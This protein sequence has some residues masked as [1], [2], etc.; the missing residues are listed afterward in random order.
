MKNKLTRKLMLS[1]FTLLFAVISLGASTY[2]WFTMS[3]SAK[4][5]AFN[6]NVK[7]GQGIEIA[8]TSTKD[9]GEA[10]WYV[11]EVPAGVIQDVA[12]ADDFEFDAVTINNQ[13]YNEVTFKD[14]NNAAKTGGYIS[15]FVHV[16]AAQKGSVSIDDITLETTNDNKWDATVPFTT[17]ANN[18]LS[19]KVNDPVLF[20]V[21]DAARI[22]F[23]MDGGENT[24]PIQIYEKDAE[25]AVEADQY[26]GNSEG[27]PTTAGAYKYYDAINPESK[28]NPANIAK[29]STSKINA[30]LGDTTDGEGK[31]TKKSTELFDINL[32]E[33]DSDVVTFQVLVWIEGW[34]GECLNAIFAQNLS[35]TLE[36]LFTKDETVTE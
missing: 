24:D 1:A 30:T 36:F 34:D 4:I 26:A 32:Y 25:D 13:G 17:A 14:L 35:V 19:L 28:L 20:K 33:D 23:I 15:F 12:V 2:A 18:G 8:V 11:G 10:Q 9:F 16:K 29:Y 21:E 7:A 3:D 5:N 27:F 22:A 31:V 6:A